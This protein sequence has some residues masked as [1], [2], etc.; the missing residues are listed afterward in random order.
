MTKVTELPLELCLIESCFR[1]GYDTL[2]KWANHLYGWE[3]RD[4]TIDR[5][6][7][8]YTRGLEYLE[9]QLK[10]ARVIKKL[11]KWRLGANFRT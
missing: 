9:I 8:S 11:L 6:I 4:V 7:I 2:E 5:S 1:T 3:L 10:R